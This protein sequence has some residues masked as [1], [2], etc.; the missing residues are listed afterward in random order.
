MTET[1]ESQK[2][3]PVRK[4]TKTADNPAGVSFPVVLVCSAIAAVLGMT[5]GTWLSAKFAAT[6]PA[7][8]LQ[9]AEQQIDPVDF[10]VLQTDLE[11]LG[12]RTA[13]LEKA[14]AD[15]LGGRASISLAHSGQ[16]PVVEPAP[17]PESEILSEAEPDSEAELEK[18]SEPEVKEVAESGPE[19]DANISAESDTNSQAMEEL[20]IELRS[21][22]DKI[23]ALENRI[24]K[25][26]QRY[27]QTDD[28]TA[29]EG[30]VQTLESQADKPPV[31][32]PP[33]PR[34]AVMDA[35]TG[36]TDKKGNWMSGL[37]GDEVRVVDADV[38][39]RL[40]RIEK[41]V[42]AGNIDAID[43]ELD[44]LPN[45]TKPVIAQWLQQFEQGE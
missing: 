45:E 33:F 28:V 1:R 3:K 4:K 39:A 8:E 35:L 16:V 6:A 17:S 14:Q 44:Y 36:K 40:D 5:G 32:I 30:R 37:L 10:A 38:T 34:E 21:V 27:A 11:K 13:N 19:I 24:K 18:P 42:E 29:L 2:P 25:Q 41:Y 15:I 43:K 12:R 26:A 22:E 9:N 31:I 20:E 7:A 23:A